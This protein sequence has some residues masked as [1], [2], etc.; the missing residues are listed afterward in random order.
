MR[1]T[2]PLPALR[3]LGVLSA[4]VGAIALIATTATTAHSSAVTVADASAQNPATCATGYQPRPGFDLDVCLAGNGSTVTPSLNIHQIGD[5][6]AS[7]AIALEI[8]DDAN[9]RLDSA[10]PSGP[11]PCATGQ[12]TGTPLDLGTL[13]GVTANAAPDGSLSVHAFA[14]LT[15]DG[16]GVYVSGQGDSPTFTSPGRGEG[17][18]PNGSTQTP[19]AGQTAMT[20]GACAG[21]FLSTTTL[22]LWASTQRICDVMLSALYDSYAISGDVYP[23]PNTGRDDRHDALRHC[24]WQGLMTARMDGN[25]WL[26]RTLGAMH[27]IDGLP[28]ALQRMIREDT[29]MDLWNNTVAQHAGHTRDAAGITQFCIDRA[30]TAHLLSNDQTAQ[31]LNLDQANDYLVILHG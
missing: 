24:L 16:Q 20:V 27:E 13:S 3:T 14:R 4:G 10:V 19:P 7:C 28:A 31:H 29:T 23:D 17:N 2:P 6:G 25:D 22:P 15:V 9:N 5:T 18:A 8:W 21:L 1:L 30:A 11:L 12:A 26:A